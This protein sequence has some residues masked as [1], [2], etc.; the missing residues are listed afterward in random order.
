[1][2]PQ[3]KEK[4]K[5]H[6]PSQGGKETTEILF[7]FFQN[8]IIE[9]IARGVFPRARFFISGFFPSTILALLIMF[10]WDGTINVLWQ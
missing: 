1:M 8:F 7:T 5:K 6:T 3:K 9:Q 4:K 10:L 2:Y